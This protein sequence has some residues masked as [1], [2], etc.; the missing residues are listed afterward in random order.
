MSEADLDVQAALNAL[1]DA[2]CALKDPL[3]SEAEVNQALAKLAAELGTTRPEKGTLV[4]IRSVIDKL[5]RP[6]VFPRDQDAWE[7]HGAKP[8]SF[9][10]WK[11]RI[12]GLVLYMAVDMLEED[13]IMEFTAYHAMSPTVDCWAGVSG[14]T[15]EEENENR[16]VEVANQDARTLLAAHVASYIARNKE[17]ATYEGWVALLHPENVQVDARLLQPGCEHRRIWEAALAAPPPAKDHPCVRAHH[18]FVELTIG[19]F[20]V[21]MVSSAAMLLLLTRIP[22]QVTAAA[23]RQSRQESSARVHKGDM[24]SVLTVPVCAIAGTLELCFFACVIGLRLAEE[25]T[26][27]ALM[28][29]GTL[30]HGMFALS[31][32]AGRKALHRLLAVRRAVRRRMRDKH[33]EP[34]QSAAEPLAEASA[35]TVRRTGVASAALMGGAGTEPN[36]PGASGAASSSTSLSPPGRTAAVPARTQDADQPL[37]VVVGIPVPA[38]RSLPTALSPAHPQPDMPPPRLVE[39]A[40]VSF[41]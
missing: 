18:S 15:K 32:S 9:K 34:A 6:E 10:T 23:M 37:P 41:V 21:I 5:E 19:S 28:G 4:A 39:D 31:P 1:E 11:Q 12:N 22:M 17:R 27:G 30:L 25:V 35:R 16:Q 38:E 3:R 24:V 14:L 26:L 36:K 8:R 7:M 29:V 13:A 20:F 33:A 40:G 2:R